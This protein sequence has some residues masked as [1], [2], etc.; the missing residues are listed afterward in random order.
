MFLSMNVPDEMNV[1]GRLSKPTENWV[2][3]DVIMIRK[4]KEYKQIPVRKIVPRRTFK[5]GI[6][7]NDFFFYLTTGMTIG[8]WIVLL[9][10]SIYGAYS[11]H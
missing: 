10:W 5:V 8:S 3:D 1:L 7:L 2:M 4:L 9:G 6:S 11:M